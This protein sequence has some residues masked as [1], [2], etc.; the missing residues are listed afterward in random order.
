M[1][2]SQEVLALIEENVNR[3]ATECVLALPGRD[4]GLIP[5]FSILGDL[6]QAVAE[7]PCLAGPVEEMSR[8]VE[9]C[10]DEGRPF[11]ETTLASL[12]RLIEWL[13]SSIEAMRSE[14]PV[15]PFR[16]AAGAT[17]GA[18]K[19]VAAAPACAA[20]EEEAAPEASLDCVLELDLD[21]SRELLN[22]FHQEAADHLLQIEAALLVLERAPDNPDALSSVFRSFHTIKGNAGF[23]NLAP[24]RALAH[25][26]ESLLDRA[27]TGEI[28]LNS[29][30]ITEILKCRDV[31]DVMVRQVAA[32]LE[33]GELPTQ[34]VVVTGLIRSVRAHAAGLVRV[35]APP[36]AAPR[37]ADAEAGS[38]AP[39]FAPQAGPSAGVTL[40]PFHEEAAEAKSKGEKSG[41]TASGASVRVGIEK[42][43]FLMDVV[44]ELVIVQSQMAE[45]VRS[46][47]FA[48][49]PIERR[50]AQLGHITKELRN[51]ALS[52]RMI[53]IKPTFQKMERLARDLAS[54]LGKQI[55]FNTFG[56]ETE[57]DR[58]VVEDVADPLVHMVRNALDHGLEG[59][60]ER[61]AAGK[62]AKG[63]LSLGAYHQGGQV[64]IDLRDDGRGIDPVKVLAKA[65]SRGLVGADEEP[66]REKILELILLPGFSTAEQVTSVSGRGVG[67]D[68]VKRN[69]ERLR[70]RIE[71][72][73]EV[74]S[75]SVFRIKLPLTTAIID[76]LVLKV[77]ADSFILPSVSVQTAIR[78]PL[79]CVSR[80]PDMGEVVD[81]RGRILPLIRLGQK[82]GIHANATEPNDGIA[83]IIESGTRTC[84]LLVDEMVAKQ[85]VVIKNLGTYLDGIPF[86]TG[87]AILGDGN[88]ALILDPAALLEAA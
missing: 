12:L 54:Q 5:S 56:E 78:P 81:L 65:R 34:V 70:G 40:A 86:V 63:C 2:L 46:S 22:E 47:V 44:G 43:D 68:V 24:M 79:G 77:G 82:L 72:S 59:P 9:L 25:E 35:S 42:L 14:R 45:S 74:G 20:A 32:A 62:P 41:R 11:D 80:M 84:A 50:V 53:A 15:P 13:N 27:R 76:G 52:L 49:S 18:R 88:I 10:L 31:I 69:I 3:L 48:E 38:Q 64:V 33:R 51:T 73:S 55:D 83:L 4:E 17:G 21:G 87:G 6:R 19:A 60:E 57:L 37:R 71:I 67:M 1:S 58:T 30:L 36:F 39:G 66:A 7:E 29:N 85:E 16:A 8:R 28:R 61:R 26:V 75:G 23:L